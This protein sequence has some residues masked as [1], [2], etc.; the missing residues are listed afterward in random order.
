MISR[1]RQDWRVGREMLESR[2]EL[3]RREIDTL[4]QQTAQA[5]NDMGEVDRKLDE[6]RAQN[7]ELAQATAGLGEAVAKLE[8]R[9]LAA[10]D[11]VPVPIRDRVKPLSQ[12]IPQDPAQTK[13]TLSERFQNVVG[14]LNE[15]NKSARE[16]LV[17]SE[18]RDLADG[19]KSEVTVLY[20]GLAQAYYC[21]AGGG[22]A[23]IGRPEASG[24]A[25][26]AD[27]ELV[28]AVAETIAVQRNEK[29]AAYVRLPLTV[30]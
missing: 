30:K 3:V 11:R 17:T 25:W 20:A 1:E 26:E 21:N 18:V 14:I 4:R 5:T 8:A 23:G 15:I 6:L 10:L 7:A 16:L 19:A 12:R 9:M 28:P 29:P 24:W 2:T 22:I 27:N 13:M